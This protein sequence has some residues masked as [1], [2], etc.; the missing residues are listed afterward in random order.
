MDLAA[1]NI[2]RGHDLGLPTLNQTREALGLTPYSELPV[3]SPAIRELSA[4]GEK[5]LRALTKLISG[6]EGCRR[7]MPQVPWSVRP[8]S[9]LLPINSQAL[10]DGDRCF[11][12]QEQGFDAQYPL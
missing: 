12:Y 3:K 7:D 10:R 8:S 5:S 9:R 4:P 2:Q 11:W 1:I 6:L